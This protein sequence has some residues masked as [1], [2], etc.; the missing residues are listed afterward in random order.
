MKPMGY[1]VQFPVS[2][3]LH[4]EPADAQ[5]EDAAYDYTILQIDNQNLYDI[6]NKALTT[7][8]SFELADDQYPDDATVN[9]V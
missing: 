5:T 4:V 6:I 1:I 3:Y 8:T 9:A 2:V 7:S